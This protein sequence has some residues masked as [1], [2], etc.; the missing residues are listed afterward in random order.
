M[1]FRHLTLLTAIAVG[2]IACGGNSE[3]IN[4]YG[5][6]S[7][8]EIDLSDIK[9]Y[10]RS[11]RYAST[12]TACIGGIY[13]KHSCSLEELPFL[14]MEEGMVTDAQIKERL[15]VSH[16]WMGNRF[17]AAL[18]RFPDEAKQLFGS[19]TAIVIDADI[20]PS[21]YF[22]ASGAIY[23]DPD[24]L[25]LTN[26]EKQTISVQ[27]DYRNSFGEDLSL[28]VASRSIKNDDYA[29]DF[30]SLTDDQE[31]SLDDIIYPLM[32][33]L[34]HE[35]THAYDFFP[36]DKM[37]TAN[38]EHTAFEAINALGNDNLA[39]SLY[40]DSALM[41]DTL[42]DLGRVLF[43]GTPVTDEQRGFTA[44]YTGAL[45][46]NDTAN[47]M[48]NYSS[49]YEDM[50]MLVEA[51]LM[52]RYFDVDL[53]IAFLHR[54]LSEELSSCSDYIVGWGERNRIA[55]PLVKNR[56]QL[57][58]QLVMPEVDWDLFFTNGIG[59]HSRMIPGDSW[60]D[61][62]NLNSRT[63]TAVGRAVGET[64]DEVRMDDFLEAHPHRR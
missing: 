37:A 2:V 63:V 33:L 46:A 17:M 13:E 23:L 18:R 27:E 62:L 12:L 45:F 1:K 49:R 29:Y 32:G 11:S 5:G 41:S 39:D 16:V 44:D 24:N 53:D 52:K 59:E 42:I 40:K 7:P 47:H 6:A 51:V 64:V 48:Y 9:P 61:N 30:Y 60:C 54:P 26:E 4:R 50:A 19:V 28:I 22:E 34:F 3:S 15:M 21:F 20:R 43:A 10:S 35:L 58:A 36:A 31:R 38:R 8:S 14:G 25:W 56:A 57:A 55:N